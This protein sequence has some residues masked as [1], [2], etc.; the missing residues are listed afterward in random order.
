MEL[1]F[2]RRHV[3]SGDEQIDLNGNKD[4]PRG[5]SL[6]RSWEVN[7]RHPFSGPRHSFQ[8]L[9]GAIMGGGCKHRDDN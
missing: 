2:H 7:S 9:I 8:M 6:M 1:H 4:V 3:T 5:R